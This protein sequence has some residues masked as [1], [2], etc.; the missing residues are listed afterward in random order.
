MPSFVSLGVAFLAGLASVLSPCVLPLIPSYLTTM[1]GTSLTT[2]AITNHRV[3]LR[4]IQ[5]SLLFVLGFSLILVA[6]GLT[7]SSL[8]QFIAHH[9]RLI[10]ELGGILIIVFGLEI[11]GL[12]DIGML[13]R[14]HH[15]RS[16]HTRRW[17]SLILGLVFAAGWT[18]CVGPILA[19][20]LILAAASHTAWAGALLLSSYALG[21][22]V[23]FL[24]LAAFLGQ[25][26]RWTRQLGHYLPWI[27]RIA[28]GLLVALGILLLTGW[29]DL[30][31]NLV[32]TNL[33]W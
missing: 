31:P 12:I 30:I 29:F 2:E 13:K 4:V 20:V 24:A 10:A 22:A 14:D 28:G 21:L 1:A 8:G 15:V 32:T 9:R 6:A 25:A 19:S 3:R 17:S 7:A 11:T 26:T 5:N 18:P 33:A 27:E 23:P 16:R